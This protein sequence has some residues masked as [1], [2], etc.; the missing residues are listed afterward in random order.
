MKKLALAVTLTLFCLSVEGQA[1]ISTA[2]LLLEDNTGAPL[3]TLSAPSSGSAYSFLFPSAPGVFSGATGGLLFVSSALGSDMQTSLLLPGTDGQTLQLDNGVPAWKS[4]NT[5][6]G[7]TTMNATLI[8]NGTNWVENTNVTLT[9]S[10]DIF[11]AGNTNTTGNTTVGGDLTVTGDVILGNGVI[12]NNELENDDVTITA[13]TGLSGGG[14]VALGGTITLNNDGILD[15]VGTTNQVNVAKA[16]GV[17]TLSTPQDIHT[18]ASPTF[19]GM[20]LTGLTG[21]SAATDLVVSNGGVLETIPIS[22]LPSSGAGEPYVTFGA[23]SAN[24]TNNRIATAGTGITIVDAGTDNGSLTI[25][26]TGLLGAAAGTGISVS[27]AGQVATIE[28]TGVTNISVGTGLSATGSTGAITLTNTGITSV[29]GTPNQVNVSTVGGVATLSTPQDIHTGASPIFNGM[30]LTGLTNDNTVTSIVVSDGGVL[31]T[32]AVTSLPG[33]FTGVT[34]DNTLTGLGILGNVLGIDL[35]NPNTWTGAQT[36]GV[37]S[38]TGNTTLGNGGDNVTVDATTGQFVVDGLTQDNTLTDIL[39]QDANGRVFTRDVSSIS[40]GSSGWA[41]TGNAGTA[42]ATNFLG[43]TDAQPLVIRSN[44]VERARVL[45]SGPMQLTSTAGA[46][47][48]LRFQ[49]PTTGG[50]DYSSFEAQPQSGHSRYILPDSAG[51]VG[52]VQ[53]LPSTGHRR[54]QQEVPVRSCL[55]VKPLMKQKPLEIHLFLKTMTT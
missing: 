55:H 12:N 8:W 39:V 31:K 19:N 9:P 49:E 4:V 21:P 11:N 28:N 37:M 33:G 50:T 36:F 7:G 34:T 32:R 40:G 3:V 16:A 27:T 43:T 35:A 23:G 38:T 24:L 13:G 6:P 1:Q 30:T 18:G 47:G 54:T 22:S 42:P 20:T 10:G 5:L 45:S 17:A 41:L 2:D 26:N 14:T 48:E 52:D 25:N 44:N 29:V 51:I 53:R 15:V 46:T